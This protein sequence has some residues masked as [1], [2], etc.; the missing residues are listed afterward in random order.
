MA[1]LELG[2]ELGVGL[3]LGLGL[4]L[5]LGVG[6]GPAGRVAPHDRCL[7]AR[8]S[9]DLASGGRVEIVRG[10]AGDAD[11]LVVHGAHEVRLAWGQG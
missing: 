5:G 9:R 4:G 10:E 6:L 7:G 1:G 8:C 3:R 2:L 11:A